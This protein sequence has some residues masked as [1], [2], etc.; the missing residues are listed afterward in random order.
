MIRMVGVIGSGDPD[1]PAIPKAE[2]VGSAI[3]QSGYGLVCGGLTG[4]MEGACRGAHSI[5][6]DDS[7]RIVGI[8]PGGDRDAAN[9]YVDVVVP[10]G[11]GLARNVLVVATAHAVVAVGGGSGT[12][13]EAA[14]AWQLDIPT[15]ALKPAGGWGA[16]LAGRSLDDKHG[17]RI[18][19]AESVA[20]VADWLR[21]TLGDG[22]A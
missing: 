19:L 8:L 14:F 6:G 13:S 17:G 1:S 22:H 20:E 16:R 18:H 5:L 11:L 15:C 4:V 7:G 9:P 12:L 2:A 10:T 3:A 21:E